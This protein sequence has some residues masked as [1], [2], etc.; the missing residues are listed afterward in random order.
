MQTVGPTPNLL[1][2]NLHFL[3]CIDTDLRIETFLSS[4]IYIYPPVKSS[5]QANEYIH[6]Y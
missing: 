2:Q 3:Q 1:N 5:S 4:G 6:H